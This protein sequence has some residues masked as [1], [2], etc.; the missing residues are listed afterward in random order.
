MNAPS[1]KAAKNDKAHKPGKPAAPLV[2]GKLK[3]FKDLKAVKLEIELR[4]RLAQ[5]LEAARKAAAA[6]TRPRKN[7]FHARWAPSRRCPSNTGLATAPI[8][9]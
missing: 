4:A 9:R 6:K 2:R 1:P 7:C 5:E 3:D 8:C